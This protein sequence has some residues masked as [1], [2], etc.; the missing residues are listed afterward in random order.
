MEPGSVIH[1]MMKLSAI[2]LFPIKSAAGISVTQADVEQRGLKDDRRWM[3][4]DDTGCFLTGRQLPA[5]V[6][7]QARPDEEGLTLLAPDMAT[8]RVQK[9]GLEALRLKVKVWDDH[10]DALLADSM[11]NAWLSRYL[12]REVRL[13]YMDG[14]SERNVEID[15]THGKVNQPVSFADGYPLLLI[16][17][18]SMTSL[19]QKLAM[20]ISILRFRPNLVISG[21]QA[22]V[23][24]HWKRIRI[25]VIEFDLIKACTR[26]VFT[27]VDP[28]T[29]KKDISGE[30]L[31]TLKE[32]RR[33]EAGIIFGMNLVSRNKGVV[34]LG[35][36]VEV[37]D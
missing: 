19:N 17:E 13:V 34:K 24:D 37:F 35:D 3:I 29:G 22:H 9:P 8:Q 5:M 6:L 7:I 28:V 2:N 26:C 21:T 23:E 25:G 1:A 32:Y 31:R 20:P 12:L 30:P 10:L 33:S 11:T 4:V 18:A 14:T 16:S 27:T 36:E 15:Q